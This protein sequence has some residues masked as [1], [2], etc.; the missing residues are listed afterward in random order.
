MSDNSNDPISK[1]RQNSVNI[2]VTRC[3]TKQEETREINHSKC[4]GYY[5]DNYGFGYH[6]RC[7]CPCHNEVNVAN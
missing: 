7:L 4:K 1:L 6:V 5:L 2:V 3:L